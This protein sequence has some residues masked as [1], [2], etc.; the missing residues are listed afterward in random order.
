MYILIDVK[1]S[2]VR[3]LIVVRRSIFLHF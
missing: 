1:W 3:K 2:D